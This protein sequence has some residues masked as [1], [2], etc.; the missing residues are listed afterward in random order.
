MHVQQQQKQQ[1]HVTELPPGGLSTPLCPT[2]ATGSLSRSPSLACALLVVETKGKWRKTV[3]KKVADVAGC[4]LTPPTPSKASLPLRCYDTHRHRMFLAPCV[5]IERV[6]DSPPHRHALSFSPGCC[7]CCS[8]AGGALCTCALVPVSLPLSLCICALFAVPFCPVSPRV[9][10]SFLV[11]YFI[12]FSKS[13]DPIT[14]WLQH[15]HHHQQQQQRHGTA[16]TTTATA[17]TTAASAA[18][19]GHLFCRFLTNQLNLRTRRRRVKWGAAAA[20]VVAPFVVVVVVHYWPA[21][22]QRKKPK[23]ITFEIKKKWLQLATCNSRVW[24]PLSLSTCIFAKL[25]TWTSNP[26]V[27]VCVAK[28]TLPQVWEQ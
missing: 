17:T 10:R 19:D 28:N 8:P 23:Q 27:Y 12:L 18:T 26:C 7:C 6:R 2:D 16:A 5:S 13:L 9:E 14:W 4:R 1:T 3:K 22:L 25:H 24:S 21:L 20:V 11:F 15:R